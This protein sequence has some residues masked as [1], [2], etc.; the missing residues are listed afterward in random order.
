VVVFEIGVDTVND[1]GAGDDED[2]AGDDG[3]D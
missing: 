1:D 2:D 3:H